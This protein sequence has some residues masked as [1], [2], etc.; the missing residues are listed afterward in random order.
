MAVEILSAA[1]NKELRTDAWF[2]ETAEVKGPW[3]CSPGK[4][5]ISSISSC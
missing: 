4:A 3:M 5:D 2:S 1:N